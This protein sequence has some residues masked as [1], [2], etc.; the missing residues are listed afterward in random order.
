MRILILLILWLFSCGFANTH[1]NTAINELG[2]GEIGGNNKGKYVQK[3]NNGL[4]SS[5]CAG[6]V[7]WVLIESGLDFKHCLS[8]KK[9]YNDGKK[10]TN[11]K[12]GDII[13][14]WRV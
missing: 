1:I 14:F 6:F 8:A 9:I 11:P 10:I 5:W 3:Y 2:N 7:S 12:P 4:E 13:C